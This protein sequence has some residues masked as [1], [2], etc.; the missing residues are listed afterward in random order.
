MPGLSLFVPPSVRRLRVPRI[1][2]SPSPKPPAPTLP[3]VARMRQPAQ[4]SACLQSGQRLGGAYYR[5]TVRLDP[6]AGL[7]RIGFAVSR[8]VDRRA[9]VRNRI[10]RIA[11]EL[12]RQ[13]RADLPAGDYVFMGR[14]EAASASRAELRRDLERLLT[15]MLALKPPAPRVT[16]APASTPVALDPANPEATDSPSLPPP[17][18][19]ARRRGDH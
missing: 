12:F 13:R 9:V 16:I 15:R 6:E 4:F 18:A 5:C 7:A 3:A 2:M 11:R 19:D 17:P 8:K 10:K 14:R 1:D